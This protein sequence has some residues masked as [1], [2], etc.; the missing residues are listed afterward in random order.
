MDYLQYFLAMLELLPRFC[1]WFGASIL[2]NS[3]GKLLFWIRG[4]EDWKTSD[5]GDPAVLALE[6]CHFYVPL[7]VWAG[8]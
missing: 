4:A 1:S 6:N 2:H 3:I 8:K 7:Y 5:Q